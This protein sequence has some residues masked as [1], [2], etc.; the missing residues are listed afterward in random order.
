MNTEPPW[1]FDWDAANVRH[2]ADHRITR[3]EFSKKG[4]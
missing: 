3:S 2:L 4:E 1:E